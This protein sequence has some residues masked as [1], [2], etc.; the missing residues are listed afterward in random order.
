MTMPPD[1]ESA[2]AFADL[3]GDALRKALE[4][5]DVSRLALE[6]ERFEVAA[7]RDAAQEAR[8]EAEREGER[9]ATAY[10]NERR[11]QLIAFTRQEVLRE[12]AVKHLQAGASVGSVV[13]MLDA[14]PAFVE[15]LAG[16]LRGSVHRRRPAFETTRIMALRNA[17]VKTS[18]EGRG[19]TVYY[20][21]TSYAF[22]LWWEFAMPPALVLLGIPTAATWEAVTKMP[23]SE[24]DQVLRFMA[25]QLIADHT[26]G[27]GHYELADN[28]LTIFSGS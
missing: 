19:G 18:S 15:R 4:A 27:V 1:N 3:F 5:V 17:Q 25:E 26:H 9:L 28:I 8:M 11:E 7:L 20:T 21:D 16:L 13:E 10:F 14:D 24:R 2:N 22:E 6:K 12:L 23:L